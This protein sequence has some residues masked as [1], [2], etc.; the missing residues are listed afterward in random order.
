MLINPTIHKIVVLITERNINRF[1]YA[2]YDITFFYIIMYQKLVFVSY[3]LFI[4]AKF[5]SISR[6]KMTR[7]FLFRSLFS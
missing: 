4:G 3:Y 1:P 2:L 6:R 5:D 7:S